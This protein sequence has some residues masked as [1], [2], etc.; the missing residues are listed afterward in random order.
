[1][2]NFANPFTVMDQILGRLNFAKEN[3]DEAKLEEVLDFNNNSRF[4]SLHTNVL[5]QLLLETWHEKHED[6][7]MTLE[8]IKDPASIPFIVESINV[9]LSYYVG[10]DIPRKAIWA[11][12]AINTPE[13]IKEI[14]KLTHSKDTFT[15]EHA[16]LNLQA[17]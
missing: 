9:K 5:C 7:L 17:K 14:E 1:V 8:A 3:K 4:Y 13:A 11:L 16:L 6:I 10:N 2:R 12:R 15:R